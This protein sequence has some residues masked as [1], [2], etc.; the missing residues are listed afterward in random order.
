M[1]NSN[2]LQGLT[3]R[4]FLTRVVP[5]CSLVCLG[6]TGRSLWGDHALMRQDQQETDKAKHKFDQEFPQ[7]LTNRQLM[8]LMY[9]REFIPFLEHLSSEIG[10]DKL[11]PM[12]EQHAEGKGREVGATLAKQFKGNDFSTWKKIFRPDNRNFSITLSMSVTEDTDTV[13]EL[14]VT[15]CLFADVFLKADAGN[16]GHAAVC[17]GDF[18]MASAF[19]PRIKM[20]RDKTLM[21]GHAFC[22]HRYLLTG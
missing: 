14:K 19:N 22:N 4:R 5:A 9:G 2:D 15:E 10:N 6:A 20:E 1:N 16:L 3:R 21:Q 18:A 8:D 12:L 7:K 17:H 11:I 13:H